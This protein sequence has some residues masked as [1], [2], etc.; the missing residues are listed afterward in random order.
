MISDEKENRRRLKTQAKFGNSVYTVRFDTEIK[1]PYPLY[2]HRYWFY[3]QDAVED[4]PE[5][6]VHWDNFVAFVSFSPPS[7]SFPFL[8]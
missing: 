5:Y 1:T 8:P 6:V 2:G 4:V 7:L 3:L